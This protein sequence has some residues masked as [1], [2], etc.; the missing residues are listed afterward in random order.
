VVNKLLVALAAF[1]VATSAVAAT[2]PAPGSSQVRTIA[3]SGFG[4]FSTGAA[5]ATQFMMP[6]GVALGAEG[7]V[8]IADAA[9]QRI[10]R[11]TRDGLVRTVAGSGS[12]VVPGVFVAGGYRDG[13]ADVAQFN[14]PSALAV[15]SD[16]V[17]VADMANHCIRRIAEGLV[18]TFAGSPKRLGAIDGDRLAAS[19]S[20]PRAL[21]FDN[22]ILYVA[23]ASVGIRR[24]S[25]S[26]Q[27]STLALPQN[28][29]RRVTSMSFV[30]SGATRK[31]IISNVSGF[32]ALDSHF[33]VLWQRHTKPRFT[34][35]LYGGEGDLFK[36]T[37]RANRDPVGLPFAMVALGDHRIAYV[38]PH[39]NA[40]RTLDVDSAVGDTRTLNSVTLDAP[41]DGGYA[42]GLTANALFDSPMGIAR[43]DDGG[44][45]IADTANRRIRKIDDAELEKPGV[46]QRTAAL[47]PRFHDFGGRKVIVPKNMVPLFDRGAYRISYLGNSLAF[48]DTQWN[49]SIPGLLEAHLRADA[50]SLGV[51]RPEVAVVYILPTFH[52]IETYVNFA[53]NLGTT[54]C[55]VI[56][57]NLGQVTESYPLGNQTLPQY[58]V[59]IRSNIIASVRR[60]HRNLSRYGVPVLFVV[61]PG[62]GE[63]SPLESMIGWQDL[64]PNRATGYYSLGFEEFNSPTPTSYLVGIL[65]AAKVPVIDLT[66]DFISA[67]QS[68]NRLPL[69]GTL[70]YH[71][72]PAG[73]SL[74][75]ERVAAGLEH[76]HPW[77]TPSPP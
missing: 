77:R 5:A 19:F 52:A 72:A 68:S 63:L 71:F 50:A 48:W 70:D 2:L 62:P 16:G 65:N 33:G 13:A 21:L 55:V 11:L 9:A 46:L 20:Y 14:H 1:S 35:A 32:L 10:F 43:S 26:G 75:A 36:S 61:H 37:V 24:I 69:F 54:D 28:F 53:L 67:E 49:D 22:G 74:V 25:P 45:I 40:V 58:F 27:V 34:E 7:D 56:Q 44:L 38:D 76:L 73:R 59:R 66:S 3:G 4:G 30:G 60:I 42:D 17:Y 12:A 41:Y 8:Y 47:P 57:L 6:V 23:D 64:N 31:L 51:H 39:I 29:D 18:S 15:G